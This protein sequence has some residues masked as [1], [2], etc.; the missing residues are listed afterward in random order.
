MPRPV[1]LI[2]SGR[3]WVRYLRPF[4]VHKKAACGYFVRKK[5]KFS[6]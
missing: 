2:L 6:K 1:T 3:W 4:V 5:K